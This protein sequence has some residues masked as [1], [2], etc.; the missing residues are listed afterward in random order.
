LTR[1][2]RSR[3][4]FQKSRGKIPKKRKKSLRAPLFGSGDRQKRRSSPS[5]DRG[6][7]RARAEELKQESIIKEQRKES[8][9]ETIK[10]NHTRNKNKNR[11]LK[12]Y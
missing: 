8:K 3:A 5:I 4:R 10:E 11:R 12:H 7:W 2:S 9:N 6:S 1:R